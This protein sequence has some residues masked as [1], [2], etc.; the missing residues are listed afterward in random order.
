VSVLDEKRIVKEGTVEIEGAIGIGEG[1]G[2]FLDFLAQR[3]DDGAHPLA[4]G[5]LLLQTTVHGEPVHL[6]L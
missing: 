3:V 4:T 5:R 6:E 1:L 2:L